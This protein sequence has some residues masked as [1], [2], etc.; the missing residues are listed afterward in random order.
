MPPWAPLCG[1]RL[2]PPASPRD[3]VTGHSARAVVA[4]I[5]LL[6]TAAGIGEV[7][8]HHGAFSFTDFPAAVV[9]DEHGLACQVVLLFLFEISTSP[10]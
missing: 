2:R 4:Q 3:G 1:C 10:P 9:T 6:R 7:Q 8:P 5:G